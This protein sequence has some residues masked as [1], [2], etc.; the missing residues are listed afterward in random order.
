MQVVISVTVEAVQYLLSMGLEPGTVY[1]CETGKGAT[2][3][4]Y[5]VD[6]P[7]RFGIVE[8]DKNG[9]AISIEE[10]PEHPKSNYCVTGLYFYDNQVVD[11]AK[12]LNPSARGEFEITNLNRVYLEQG[13][14]N[15][16]LLG[17]GFTWLDTGT[18]E[19]LVDATVFVQTIEMTISERMFELLEQ[20]GISQKEFSEKMG[21]AQQHKRL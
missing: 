13:K 6:D 14:L 1:L 20:R 19:S 16:E 4:G 5:Y 18:H 8:F 17:Q 12:T 21:I 7:E 2:I 11:I 15:V 3:F 10:K 9:H